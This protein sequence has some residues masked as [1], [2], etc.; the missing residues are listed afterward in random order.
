MNKI[1]LEKERK[2]LSEELEQ[3][4]AAIHSADERRD[5]SPFGKR[6]EVAT[7]SSELEKSIAQQNNLRESLAEVEHA[8][9]KFEKG[10]YGMCDVCGKP[11]AQERLE[12]RPHAAL[13]IECKTNLEKHTKIK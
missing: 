2:R 1:R 8:L 12:A 9:D 4:Q 10:T 7:E 13:C 11:I 3:L 6:E 5:G